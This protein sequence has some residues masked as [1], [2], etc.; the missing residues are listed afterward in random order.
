MSDDLHARLGRIEGLIE[1]G[2]KDLDS[3]LEDHSDRLTHLEDVKNKAWGFV[4]AL[5]ATGAAIG[6]SVSKAFA[7]LFHN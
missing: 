3:K 5:G 6:A 4:I 1:R 7:S 2:F